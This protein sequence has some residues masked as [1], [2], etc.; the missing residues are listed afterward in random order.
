MTITEDLLQQLIQNIVNEYAKKGSIGT[1]TLCDNIEK[2]DADAEQVDAIYK[3]L[4][5]NNIKIIDD[6]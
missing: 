2:Y 4:E 1:D 3:A 6:Y 5:S